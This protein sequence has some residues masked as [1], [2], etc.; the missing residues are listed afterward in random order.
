MSIG[1]EQE[2]VDR[3][4]R[5]RAAR[6]L[7]ASGHRLPRLQDLANPRAARARK[8]KRRPERFPVFTPARS[9]WPQDR[10]GRDR[11]MLDAGLYRR[12]LP[13][14]LRAQAADGIDFTVLR[15]S[16][17]GVLGAGASAFDNV[18]EALDA[19]ANPLH[20]FCRRDLL[21]TIQPLRYI[22]FYGFLRHLGDMDDER[23]WRFMQYVLGLRESFTQDAYDRCTSYP[24]FKIRTGNPW[25]DVTV[26]EGRAVVT[27]PGGGYLICGTG[28]GMDVALRPEFAAFSEHIAT[29]ADRHT[30]P[31]DEEGRLG[32]Y[33]S[34][35]SDYAFL[36]KTPGAARFLKYI[37]CF[38]I[39]ACVSYGMSGAPINAMYVAV[40][41]L[42]A[43]VTRGLFAAK[44]EHHWEGLQA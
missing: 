34:L 30:P 9:S 25:L 39:G 12:A 41:K 11:A 28:G 7:A 27:T 32:R 23:R 24:H 33:P 16:T 10:T 36:E 6:Q 21:Q 31:Q 1:L 40:S 44:L 5:D 35:G 13:A 19:G 42:V 15:G 37:H 22:T 8:W 18:A 3:Q 2:I 26:E 29:W 43:G 4:V 17:V 20:L 38:G 14:H